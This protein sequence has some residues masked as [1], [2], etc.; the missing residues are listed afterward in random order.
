VGWGNPRCQYRLRDERIESSPAEEILRVLVDEKLSMTWQRA[1]A[2]QK[3]NRTLG[4]IKSSVA[5][6]AREVILPLC[7]GETPPGVLCPA[8]E[9]LTQEGRG[10]VGAGPEEATKMIRGLEHLSCEESLREFGLRE[11]ESLSSAWKGEGSCGDLIAD[12]QYL[13]EACKKDGDKLFSR[14]CCNQTRGN[15]FKLRE[16]RFRLDIRRKFFTLRVV[17]RWHSLPR[18]VVDVPSLERP[19]WVGL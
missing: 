7:S 6:R 3:A 12:F 17:E 11:R 10:A 15:G 16:G 8:L 13:K 2:A 5:S 4:C 9:P 19:G 18:E 1:L 14:A